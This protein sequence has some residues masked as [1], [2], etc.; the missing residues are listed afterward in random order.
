M[1]PE[2]IPVDKNTSTESGARLAFDIIFFLLII[3]TGNISI[4]TI[5]IPLGALLVLTW[6]YLSHT[7][8]RDIG[9]I[10]PRNIAIT[11]LTALV[12]GAVFK[13]MMKSVVM[14]LF[15]APPMNLYYHYLAGNTKLLPAA[16]WAMLVAGFGEETV[17][18]GYLFNR[19]GKFLKGRGST[20][21]IVLITSAWFAFGHYSN[22][23]WVGVE[24]AAI[25]GL[26]FGT[27]YG[28]TGRIWFVII[29]HAAFDLMALAMIYWD[30]E[31]QFAHL[32][33]K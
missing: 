18:R 12:F 6:T 2:E 33:F 25:T 15:G 32:F 7:S 4:G 11:I 30:L 19:I 16:V 5:I 27:I 23:G 29:A 1:T 17:F 21:L 8:F 26:V 31:T 24:Q 22:Q 14:P 10:R 13:I 20:A 3:L 9:Y 28:I